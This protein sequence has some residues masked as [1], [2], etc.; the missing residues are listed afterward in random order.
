MREIRT[1]GS[2]RGGWV[3]LMS[4][5]AHSPTLLA[6]ASPWAALTQNCGLCLMCLP[7]FILR[8]EMEH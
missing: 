5:I 6:N 3:V 4:D 1:P 8:Q 7:G 2:T